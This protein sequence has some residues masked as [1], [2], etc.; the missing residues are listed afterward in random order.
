MVHVFLNLQAFSI[1]PNTVY[2][3]ASASAGIFSFVI[4]IYS[5]SAVFNTCWACPDPYEK[6][7][8]QSLSKDRVTLVKSPLDAIKNTIKMSNGGWH[9]QIRDIFKPAYHSDLRL[10]KIDLETAGPG[11]LAELNRR[12]SDASSLALTLG[13]YRVFSLTLTHDMP[14]QTYAK[15]AVDDPAKAAEATRDM[16]QER[17]NSASRSVLCG[18]RASTSHNNVVFCLGGGRASLSRNEFFLS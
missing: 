10:M 6:I 1:S 9:Q 3:N 12:A 5:Y 17:T 16:Q 13:K 18:C 15:A 14:P 4:T 7:G 2:N 8:S 11:D